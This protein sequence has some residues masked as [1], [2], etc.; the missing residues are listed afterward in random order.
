MLC[1]FIEIAYVNYL[2]ELK[3]LFLII[4]PSWWKYTRN[5]IHAMLC[6][7]QIHFLENVVE[8]ALSKSKN[9]VFGILTI[10]HFQWKRDFLK[11]KFQE[12]IKEHLVMMK[13]MTHTVPTILS[14]TGRI[15]VSENLYLAYFMQWNCLFIWCQLK[16]KTGR[17]FQH[18]VMYFESTTRKSYFVF[19]LG[20][21]KQKS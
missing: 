6:V 10:F 3:L 19:E 8:I 16:M 2:K 18:F 13:I 9:F 17:N 1:S 15:Q 20:K 5:P 12:L 14:L 21:N 7:Q 4:S 11:R